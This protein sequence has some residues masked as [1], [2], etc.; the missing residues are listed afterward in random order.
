[1]NIIYST[2]NNICFNDSNGFII[3]ESIEFSEIEQPLYSTYTIEWFGDFDNSSIS[4]DKFQAISLKN[5]SYSFKVVSTSSFEESNLYNITITSPDLLYIS[6]VKYEE[7][8]CSD[9]GSVY[10]EIDGGVSPYFYNIGSYNITSNDKFVNFKNIDSGIYTLSVTD[11]NQCSYVWPTNIVINNSDITYTLQEILPPKLLNSFATLDLVVS[12]PGPFNFLFTNE[13]T[14]ESLYLDTFET[15]YLKTS[16]NNTYNYV[17]DD[18]LVPGQYNITI[19]NIYGCT[20][21]QNIFLP[22][23]QPITVNVS[24][25][26]NSNTND[27][28]IVDQTQAIFDTI[29]VPYKLI[30]NNSDFWQVIKNK[31]LKDNLELFINDV[32]YTYIIYKILLNKYCSTDDQL[33]IL[34]LDNDSDNWYYYFYIAPGINLGTNSEL[35]NAKIE[36]RHENKIFPITF[37]L[38]NGDLDQENP[39]LISGTFILSD[40][41]YDQFFNGGNLDVKIGEP[42]SID[43][44]EFIVQNIKKNTAYNIY[45]LG[46]VTIINFLE[47]FNVLNYNINNNQTTCNALPEDYRYIINVKKLLKA[48]NNFNNINNIYIFN[49]SYYQKNDNNVSLSVPGAQI[50]TDEGITNNYMIKYF[51]LDT[52][53]K[54]PMPL[55]A[56]SQKIENVLSISG[57]KNGHYIVRIKDFNG[58]IPRVINYDSDSQPVNYDDHFLAAKKIISNFN[59]NLIDKFMYGDILFFIGDDDIESI[60]NSLIP[61]APSSPNI[62][63]ALPETIIETI[64]QTKNAQNNNSLTINMIQNI[65]Y[66]IYGPNNYKH[67]AS[68]SIKIINMVPGVYTIIGNAEDLIKNSLYQNETRINIEKNQTYN[69]YIDFIS[70]QNDIFIKDN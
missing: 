1:M 52:V 67:I 66:Y 40:T 20:I 30:A 34:R 6:N 59:E 10:V 14:A 9:N 24:I 69:I 29:I 27:I 28:F 56:G 31:N 45:T 55:Y 46:F 35:I 36:L 37:G 68:S 43:D 21:S 70:Y 17:F 63:P 58:N 61:T 5:G 48:I 2:N 39:S 50:I 23:I 4:N 13:D 25:S 47:Y 42:S 22:N 26:N 19:K 32:K 41:G 7:Y 60:N 62:V 65:S 38:T 16:I 15:K 49:S 8:A 44:K 64:E 33:Q 54:D 57:L 11:S 18:L 51:Y 3:I 53:K 12:G